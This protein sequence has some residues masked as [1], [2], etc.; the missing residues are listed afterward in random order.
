MHITNLPNELILHIFQSTPDLPTL[1]A[2]SSS[3]KH[4]HKILTSHRLPTLYLAAESQYGPLAIA[5]RV[6]THNESQLPHIPRPAPS[7][8]FALLKQLV[9]VGRT[10]EKWIT[11]YPG[12]K[13]K[14]ERSAD[15]RF[16]NE[17]ECYRLRRACYRIWLYTLA[18]HTRAYPRYTRRQLDVMRTR[19]LLLRPW[20]SQQLAELLDLHDV[21][22]E[23]LHSHVCPSNGTVLRRHKQRF[24]D[25]PFPLISSATV[26]KCEQQSTAYS[27]AFFHSTPHVSHLSMAKNHAQAYAAVEGWGDDISQYYVVE[28]MLKVNPGQL[29]RLYESVTGNLELLESTN[30]VIM[31]GNPKGVVE[32]FVAGLGDWFENNGETLC[33]TV[34]IVILDRGGDVEAL[35]EGIEEGWEGIAR[36]EDD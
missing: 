4:F 17:E 2:L 15:R 30:T 23:V 22:R 28:D 24:P 8:S 9:A 7:Q 35:R 31:P 18:F 16:L 12:L 34:G 1:L 20:S 19:A 25:D 32:H 5:T 27:Q 6:V 11:I 21:F 14:G 13:W 33:E 3:C 29:V 10:A 36:R 26:K